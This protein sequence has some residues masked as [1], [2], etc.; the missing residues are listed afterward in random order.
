MFRFL[1]GLTTATMYSSSKIIFKNRKL[2]FLKH[3]ISF[4]NLQPQKR[5]RH[6]W[7]DRVKGT[8][9]AC[10]VCTSKPATGP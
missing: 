8:T 6:I 5:K 2:G 7:G 1:R 9:K 4:A 10:A 3:P